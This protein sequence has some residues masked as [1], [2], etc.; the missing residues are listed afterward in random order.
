MLCSRARAAWMSAQTSNHTEPRAAMLFG[1]S[2]D[3][4]IAMVKG[5]F[6]NIIRNA[7]I[8]RSIPLIRHKINIAGHKVRTRTLDGGFF[9]LGE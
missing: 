9:R 2:V 8:Q 7:Q 6:C 4:A 1:K 3:Q 5:A